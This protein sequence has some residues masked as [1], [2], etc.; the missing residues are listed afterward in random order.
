M[1]AEATA[2]TTDGSATGMVADVVLLQVGTD[3]SVALAV[4]LGCV[5]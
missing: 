4:C 5:C 2:L 3:W 1:L